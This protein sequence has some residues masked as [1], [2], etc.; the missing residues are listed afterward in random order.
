MEEKRNRYIAAAFTGYR[1]SKMPFEVTEENIR[2]YQRRIEEEI[3]RQAALGIRYFMSG[4]CNG[5]DLW[6]AEAVLRV[7][8]EK[9]PHIE[10][11]AIVPFEGQDRYFSTAEKK[12]YRQILAEAAKT[13]VLSPRVAGREAAQAFDRRNRYMVEHC[14]VLI[15]LCEHENIKPGGTRNTVRYAKDTGKTVVFLPPTAIGWRVL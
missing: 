2:R 11:Y 9:A 10:L 13:V 12:L 3:E 6:A 8:R 1:P 5:A 7:K 14:D 15:A 4:M